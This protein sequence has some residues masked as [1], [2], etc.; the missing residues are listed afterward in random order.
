VQATLAKVGAA[1]AAA[2]LPLISGTASSV[3]GGDGDGE[4][5]G[6]LFLVYGAFRFKG[7]LCDSNLRFHNSL[8]AQSRAARNAEK[9]KEATDAPTVLSGDRDAVA[10]NDNIDDDDNDDDDDDNGYG[11]MSM[12][13]RDFE[14][15]VDVAANAALRCIDVVAVPANNYV[16]VFQR[17]KSAEEAA[18][19]VAPRFVDLDDL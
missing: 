13:I 19:G 17:V 9:V 8:R 12:G 14:R 16:L 5:S 11:K 6:G 3:G 10:G 18:A 15:V 2:P 7:H 4:H 1:L